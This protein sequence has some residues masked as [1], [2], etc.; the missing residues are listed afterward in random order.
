MARVGIWFDLQSANRYWA[1]GRNLFGAYVEEILK[2][3]GMP[4]EVCAA[5]PD[6]A[7]AFDLIVAAHAPDDAATAGR[8]LAYAEQGGI[9]VSYA[10]LRCLVRQLGLREGP[11]KNADY[12]ELPAEFG[13]S[14]PLRYLRAVPWI[15][16]NGVESPVVQSFQL[17]KGRVERWAV[18]V[19]RLPASASEDAAERR[20]GVPCRKQI[21]TIP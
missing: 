2:D 12:T 13:E 10:G 11:E 18:D 4:F 21:V 9:V 16:G 17:G 6:D 8:L 3:Y 20:F 1:H 19:V 5:W 15:D 14:V 7:S